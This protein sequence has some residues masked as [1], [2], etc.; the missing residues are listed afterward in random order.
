MSLVIHGWQF[1]FNTKHKTM[2]TKQKLKAIREKCVE[3]LKLESAFRED[4]AGWKATIAAVDLF[5]DLL[6][7]RPHINWDDCGANKAI[8]EI[9]AAWEGLV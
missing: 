1:T 2:T 4:K 9:I 8:T 3:L 5:F 7:Y 6:K